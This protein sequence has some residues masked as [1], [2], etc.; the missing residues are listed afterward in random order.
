MC[1][2]IK[3]SPNIHVIA[4]WE[5]A[6]FLFSADADLFNLPISFTMELNDQ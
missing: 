1:H 3:T 2:A 5:F 4:S 6:I